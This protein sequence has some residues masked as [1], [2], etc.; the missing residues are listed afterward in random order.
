MIDPHI[1]YGFIVVLIIIHLYDDNKNLINEYF[2]SNNIQSDIDNRIYNVVGGFTDSKEAANRLSVVHNFM[3]DY[4]KY[5]KKNFIIQKKGTL[6]ENQF[7]TRVLNNYHPDKL[8]END[9]APGEDTSYILNKGEQFGLCLRS[10]TGANKGQFHD[11][12]LLKFVALHEI[13]HLGTITFGHNREFWHWFKFVLQQATAS[14]L[15]NPVDYSQDP[16]IYCGLLVSSN[17]YYS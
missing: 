11:F 17:P 4:M 7:I 16:Q 8:K 3:I 15:Y 5:L 2:Y 6:E 10:K 14:G 13:S 1:F 12:E 9:P